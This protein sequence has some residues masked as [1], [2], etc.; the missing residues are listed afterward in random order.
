MVSY[1]HMERFVLDTNLFFNMESGLGL[2]KK[3]EEVVLAM[4]HAMRELK[5][6]SKA[7]FFASPKIVDE[8]LSFFEDKN[9]PFL[10]D[11]LAVLTVKSP[12]MH[13]VLF[14]SAMTAQ[15]VDDIRSRSYRGQ[16]VAEEEIVQAAKSTMSKEALDKKSFEIHVG[17][18]IKKFRMR[19]RQATRF[20]FLDSVA[21]FELIILAKELD[22]FLVSTDEGV[23]R[24][25]RTFGIKEM[26]APVFGKKMMIDNST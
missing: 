2:G 21:D 14:P 4:T 16:S 13:N 22:A 5:N 10:K 8:F 12:D 17:P 7:E 11:F 18:L 1:T 23:I 20:G 26:A 24:W 25:A 3:T 19:Y 6:A 9:Q 15:L